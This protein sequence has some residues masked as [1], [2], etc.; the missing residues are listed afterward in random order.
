ME[1]TAT[2]DLSNFF[3]LAIVDFL[4][5]STQTVFERAAQKISTESQI[6]RASST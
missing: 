4:Q 2:V 1:L 5:I 6:S 3:W